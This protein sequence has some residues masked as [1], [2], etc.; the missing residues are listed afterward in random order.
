MKFQAAGI[1]LFTLLAAGCSAQSPSCGDPETLAKLK[2]AVV[3]AVGGGAGA[4]P[5]QAVVSKTTDGGEKNVCRAEIR[6][7]LSPEAAEIVKTVPAVAWDQDPEF[8]VGK[9]SE[10]IYAA[11]AE[12]SAAKNKGEAPAWVLAPSGDPAALKGWQELGQTSAAAL[13]SLPK[14]Q[15]DGTILFSA[16]PME[17]RLIGGASHEVSLV[18]PQSLSGAIRT[19]ETL[20]AEA[21]AGDA[22]IAKAK[23]A[24][25]A[26]SGE[27]PASESSASA[28]PR[29]PN[30]PSYDCA[31]ATS[32]PDKLVCGSPELSRL[33]RELNAV[34]VKVRAK[35]SDQG[36]S[37]RKQ[38]DWYR[39]ERNTCKNAACLKKAYQKRI[40]E[41]SSD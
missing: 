25:L 16:D 20:G 26:A 39:N 32:V 14:V 13:R 10:K 22:L 27:K 21:K 24:Q 33:D 9:G 8:M 6:W 17:F 40:R 11:F 15:K 1:L 12:E 23:D 2:E 35:S 36:W 3:K 30:G 18:I 41:L 28:A 5:E 31:K 7:K 4:T 37:R 29:D 19:A 38:M 34:W